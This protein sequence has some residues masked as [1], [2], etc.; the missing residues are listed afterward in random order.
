[1]TDDMGRVG[2]GETPYLWLMR[3]ISAC[4][5]VG[6]ARSRATVPRVNHQQRL[7]W[8]TFVSG[9]RAAARASASVRRPVPPETSFRRAVA[10]RDLARRDGPGEESSDVENLLFHLRLRDLRGRI[11]GG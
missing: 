10:L 11:L 5:R 2:V 8:Q 6:K 1:M 9:H 3:P 4:S 7:A